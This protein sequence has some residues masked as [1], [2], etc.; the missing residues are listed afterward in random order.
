MNHFRQSIILFGFLLPFL[1]VALVVGGFYVARGKVVDGYA[2]KATSFK[3]Y[4]ADQFQA[5]AIEAKI[6]KKRP[7][8]ANWAKAIHQETAS[9]AS[10]LLNEIKKKLPPK[11]FQQTAYSAGNAAGLGSVSAQQALSLNFSYRATFR[12]MQ[13]A[14]LELE[15]RMPQLQLNEMSMN[16]SPQSNTLNFQLTYTAWEE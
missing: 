2:K 3:A 16:R 10:S 5:K 4:T 15:S 13:R 6:S 7:H 12:S 14:L 8:V 11:E 1:A 9:S